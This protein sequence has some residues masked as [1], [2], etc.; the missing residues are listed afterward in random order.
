MT[1]SK[2]RR[3]WLSECRWAAHE[4]CQGYV[5]PRDVLWLI[6]GWS[7]HSGWSAAVKLAQVQQ[8]WIAAAESFRA[9]AEI[10]L[11]ARWQVPTGINREGVRASRTKGAKK[12]DGRKARKA[13]AQRYAVA[14][15]KGLKETPPEDVADAICM[16]SVWITNARARQ[17][18]LPF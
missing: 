1:V 4:V 16:G 14:T 11:V 8:S 17:S 15:V 18:K 13:A 3:T 10:M 9:S 2:N 7:R 12:G 6:E 5:E